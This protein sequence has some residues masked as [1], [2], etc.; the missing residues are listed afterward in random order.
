MTRPTSAELGVRAR[1][2]AVL[3]AT[4][5]VVSIEAAAKTLAL[6][7]TATAKLLSRWTQQGWL[8]RIG[9]GAYV[10]VPLSLTGTQQIVDD[11]WVLVPALFGECYVGG[12]TAAHHWDLTEQLFN[13]TAV[14]TT[15]R[16]DQKRV[17]TQGINF[18]VHHVDKRR[19]FGVKSIWR[20]ATRINVS[21]PARTLIDML[22]MPDSGGGIDHVADCLVAYLKSRASDP[23][24]LIQYATQF[25]NGSVFKRLGFLAERRL[26]DEGLAS[27]CREHLT[28]GY[29]KLDPALHSSH[30]ITTWRLWVPERWKHGV[31]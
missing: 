25:E 12:W 1:L 3:R 2:T 21:D 5:H 23:M 18:L 26:H 31:A 10:A 13:K 7:R 24:L 16:V 4:K 29:A 17:R 9:P 27:A 22:A 11:P 15:R 20:G 19:L 8:R 30:L 14:F 28:K 6:D